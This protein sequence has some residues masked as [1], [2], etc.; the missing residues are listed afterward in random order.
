M[1]QKIFLP[2]THNGSYTLIN[3][4]MNL[5][6][7]NCLFHIV[8]M[9]K[10]QI[11]IL[12]NRCCPSVSCIRTL[13][14]IRRQQIKMVSKTDGPG[15]LLYHVYAAAPAVNAALARAVQLR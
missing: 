1:N 9:S 12:M 15:V 14:K 8:Y 11:K 13:Y 10:Y 4:I 3:I 6:R 7:D 2:D 5:C